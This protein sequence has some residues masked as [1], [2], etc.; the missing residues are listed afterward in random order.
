MV[1]MKKSIYYGKESSR[2]HS[3]ILTFLHSPI[4]TY[5]LSLWCAPALIYTAVKEMTNNSCL[6]T[7]KIC[8]IYFRLWCPNAVGHL[9][10]LLDKSY[11]H[12]VKKSEIEDLTYIPPLFPCLSSF[13]SVRC[14][15]STCPPSTLLLLLVAGE[16]SAYHPTKCSLSNSPGWVRYLANHATHEEY[17]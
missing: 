12:P 7:Y 11:N 9:S 16:W 4:S 5:Q 2:P 8:T 15:H 14:A 3:T 13:H 1:I 6:N 10:L 17:A